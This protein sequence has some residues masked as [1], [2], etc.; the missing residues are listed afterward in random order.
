MLNDVVPDQLLAGL[1]TDIRIVARYNDMGEGVGKFGH[2][3]HVH[4]GSD[5][6]TAV[7]DV[8]TDPG[9]IVFTSFVWSHGGGGHS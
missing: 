5:I 7:A 2:L 4:R 8:Y 9:L 6:H 1:G 3:L